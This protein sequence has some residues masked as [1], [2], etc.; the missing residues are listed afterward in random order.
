MP[1]DD[2]RLLLLT[3]GILFH[4]LAY[5]GF[6]DQ[7]GACQKFGPYTI[8]ILSTNEAR[9]QRSLSNINGLLYQLFVPKSNFNDN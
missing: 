8:A 7:R 3:D 6:C 9:Y 5:A 2:V 4:S 1:E